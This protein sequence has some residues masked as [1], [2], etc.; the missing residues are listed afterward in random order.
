[1]QNYKLI[2]LVVLSASLACACTPE[3]GNHF[4]T[5]AKISPAPDTALPAEIPQKTLLRIQKNPASAQKQIL[6]TF[7]RL[8]INDTVKLEQVQEAAN[9]QTTQA[10]A[11]VMQQLMALDKNGDS[12]ISAK[13]MLASNDTQ[14]GL[15][16]KNSANYMPYSEADTNNDDIIS[17]TESFI[18]AQKHATTVQQGYQPYETLLGTFDTNQD[19]N[20]TRSE[21]VTELEGLG[22]S[23]P[24]QS[25]A[26]D[27][28][29]SRPTLRAKTNLGSSN[30][31]HEKSPPS[32]CVP[33]VPE[34]N[35]EVIFLSGYEGSGLSSVA[36]T[37][38]DR[39]TEVARIVIE[40][41]SR[42]LYIMASSYTP[43]VWSLEG[44]TKRVQRFV[45][46]RNRY[47]QGAGVG[48]VGLPNS[49]VEFLGRDCL[50]YFYKDNSSKKIMARA[51]WGKLI[52]QEPDNIF[53]AY[54][55]N[56]MR[57]PSG[58]N[59]PKN[60]K[61]RLVVMGGAGDDQIS[62]RRSGKINSIRINSPI[63]GQNDFGLYRYNKDGLIEVDV[64]AVIAPEPVETYDVFPQ[65]AGLMQ[66]VKAG[67]LEALERGSFRIVKPV[68]RFPAG[69]AGAHGVKFILGKGIPLPKGDPGH[70]SVLSEETGECLSR[71]CR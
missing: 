17:L 1:M 59:T 49:K 54:T 60:E 53:G 10:R 40:E 8:A 6:R 55:L 33:S 16:R 39:T 52:N 69:L 46:G 22:A 37:G 31:Q 12:A 43:L 5:S 38:P 25:K 64:Q 65:E 19:G 20:V 2:S 28:V 29:S 56:A 63:K 62:I 66:L 27:R 58:V 9:T 21:V 35:A 44:D 13:E 45:A 36:V 42:P 71:R 30:K 34:K 3:T 11:I 67:Q 32:A 57:L 24:T 61:R 50:S 15:W 41:G 70:S 23:V 4:K 48:V 47:K 18:F 14:I 7:D 26:S 51:T 68:S